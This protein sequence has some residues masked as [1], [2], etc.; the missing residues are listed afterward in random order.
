MSADI[1]LPRAGGRPRPIVLVV[2]DGFGIGPDPAADA[3]A[4]AD[5]PV[6]RS[7]LERWP[8]AVL[9]ASE[10]AVD[11]FAHDVVKLAIGAEA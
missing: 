1:A 5:M 3:I 7:L 9:R 4:A 6:W 8:H 2:L 10:D 11:H